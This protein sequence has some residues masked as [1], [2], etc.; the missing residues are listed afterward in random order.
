MDSGK[1]MFPHMFAGEAA[2]GT[3]PPTQLVALGRTSRRNGRI[4][5]GTGAIAKE[6]PL[7]VCQT[8]GN[9]SMSSNVASRL[10]STVRD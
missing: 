3:T 1:G 5:K 6:Q 10:A 4:D 2:R 7:S 8:S 9:W